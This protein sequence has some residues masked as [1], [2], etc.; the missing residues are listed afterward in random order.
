MM[1][2]YTAK[3]LKTC[4]YKIYEHYKKEVGNWRGRLWF[5]LGVRDGLR[6]WDRL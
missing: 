3:Y 5:K 2:Y 6:A 1:V 4:H